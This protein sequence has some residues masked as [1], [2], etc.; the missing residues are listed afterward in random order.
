MMV[1][2]ADKKKFI[3]FTFGMGILE[4]ELSSVPTDT[5]E[6]FLISNRIQ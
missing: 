5:C 1:L 6:N 3:N 2:R 4:P